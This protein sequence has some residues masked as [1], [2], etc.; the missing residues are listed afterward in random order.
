MRPEHIDWSFLKGA[1]I[2]LGVS[3]FAGGTLV[4]GSYYFKQQMQAEFTENHKSFQVISS[5]YLALDEEERLIREYYPKLAELN[6]RGFV[7]REQRLDWIETLRDASAQIRLP[8]LQY[9]I[10]SQQEYSPGIPLNLGGYKLYSSTM[11]LSI[12][13]LHEGD[14]IRLLDEL[15]READGLYTVSSC[16]LLRIGKT[17]EFNPKRNN[18]VAECELSWFSIKPASGKELKLL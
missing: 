5:R 2:M 11:K 17:I 4:G 12:G 16:K 7:G 14:L 1:V 15:N 8:S 18:L 9:Q 3:V 10:L 13:L 6:R